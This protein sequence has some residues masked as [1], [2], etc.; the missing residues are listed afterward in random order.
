MPSKQLYSF[1]SDIGEYGTAAEFKKAL[2]KFRDDPAAVKALEKGMARSRN[3]EDRGNY[4]ESASSGWD[5]LQAREKI[6]KDFYLDN[7]DFAP[8]EEKKIPKNKPPKFG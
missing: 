1:L 5:A 7:G 3:H 2:L 8:S 4:L 6:L